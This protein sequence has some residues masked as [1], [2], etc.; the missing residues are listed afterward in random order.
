T[1]GLAAVDAPK[2]LLERLR[3]DVDA[4]YSLGYVPDHR[5]DGKK[6][7]LA[8]RLRD[9]SLEKSLSV[10]SRESF[11][12]RTGVETTSARTLSALLLGE[13]V[14]PFEVSLSV[15]GE[16]RD[17]KGQCLVT[18]LVK[19]PMGKLVLLPHG[20]AHEGRMRIFVGAKD[21][22]GRVSAINEV[23]VPIRVPN[24]QI[25]TVLGQNAA[26]RVPL[27]LRPG[28]HRLAVWVRD[29]LGNADSTV[30]STYTAGSLTQ[31]AAS[32]SR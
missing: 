19:L 27:L 9:K 24:S 3:G 15:E 2:S 17:K 6:H 32:K 25:L 12:E 28:E 13:E 21:T 26:T 8:V 29:E 30:T 10:R 31:E 7:Q 20:D 22:E 18:L 16:T 11:R 14:N 1:G 23:A 5:K 4:Y